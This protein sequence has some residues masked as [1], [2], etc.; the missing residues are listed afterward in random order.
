MIE[1]RNTFLTGAAGSG[2]TYTLNQF[3]NWAKEMGKK[4][5][6]TAST[7]IAATHLN[8]QTI[9]SFS[10]MGILD[11]WDPNL[12]LQKSFQ[13]MKAPAIRKCELLII[14]EIS[15]LGAQQFEMVDKIFQAVHKNSDP[16]GGI[17]IVVC[18]DFFQLPPISKS[19]RRPAKFAFESPHWDATE[20]A[21][22]YLGEQ[23]RHQDQS[24]HGLLESIRSDQVESGHLTALD[25]RIIAA[26][27]FDTTHLYTRNLNVDNYNLGQLRKI[28]EELFTFQMT[29]S[30]A[31]AKVASLKRNCLAPELLQVKVGA[32][33]MA[34]K[35]D[36]TGK[37][38]NGSIG[39]VIDFSESADDEQPWPIVEFRNGNTCKMT[40][41]KWE[42]VENFLPSAKIVQVPLRLAWAVTIH[43]SQGLT[44]DSAYIDLTTAFELG[45]GYVALS[46]V[47]KLEDL[48]LKGYNNVALQVDRAVLEYDDSLHESS[49]VIGL[50][51]Q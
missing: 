45:M 47:R 48:T 10:G 34:L 51:Y 35:N 21:V 32:L 31:E 37:Y 6:V 26:P 42:F 15:M 29:Q 38:V 14:D 3:I 41:E 36:Y 11:H 30:G 16:F 33:V 27:S 5:A 8:G 22:C 17:Q 1:G 2:K 46:R 24:F 7:G 23:F 18:G 4:V 9:H 39:T 44:L 49:N 50:M 12:L 28:Q 20:F 13:R 40:P 19:P 25:Q 43:K